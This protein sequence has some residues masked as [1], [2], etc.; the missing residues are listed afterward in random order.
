MPGDTHRDLRASHRFD[1]VRWKHVLLPVW[2]LSYPHGGKRYVVLVNGQTGRVHGQAPWSWGKILL[3]VLAVAALL[4][5]GALALA[6]A[7]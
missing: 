7:S 2:T 6:L 4:A 1:G 3:A 5:M